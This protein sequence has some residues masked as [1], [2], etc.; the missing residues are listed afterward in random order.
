MKKLNVLFC[1][2][3]VAG[4]F[5]FASMTAASIRSEG[6]VKTSKVLLT[7]NNTETID[8]VVISDTLANDSYVQINDIQYYRGQEAS[9]IITGCNQYDG[10]IVF[11]SNIIGG[12][13]T[14]PVVGFR[15]SWQFSDRGF[16]SITFSDNITSLPDY[17]FW[18][19]RQL[20]KVVLP[21]KLQSIGNECFHA[22][23][24]GKRSFGLWHLFRHFIWL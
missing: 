18:Y 13:K 5:L 17:C 12:G 11:P 2:T 21:K 19:C 22:Q 23:Y 9:V 8:S 14:Y 6:S 10:D 4:S 24:C 7:T 16:T 1:L 15:D 3:A 20:T